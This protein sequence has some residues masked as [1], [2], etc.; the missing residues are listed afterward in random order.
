MGVFVTRLRVGKAKRRHQSQLRLDRTDSTSG[1]GVADER[2][3]PER[4]IE[5][6]TT[7]DDLF[8]RRT[9]MRIECFK[10]HRQH[11][12]YKVQH[13]NLVLLDHGLEVRGVLLAFRTRNDQRGTRH[14]G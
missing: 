2:S 1:S 4:A 13:A 10:K 6:L 8:Y 3:A 12:G 7:G 5:R 14:E 9:G 11:G